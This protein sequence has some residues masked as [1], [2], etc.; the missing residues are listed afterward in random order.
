MGAY[1]GELEKIIPQENIRLYRD[2]GLC[3][4]QGSEPEIWTNFKDC[5]LKVTIEG[6]VTESL[7][8]Y[9]DLKKRKF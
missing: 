1:D 8:V 9:F 4:V 3:V 6:N 5:K 7:E 2:D